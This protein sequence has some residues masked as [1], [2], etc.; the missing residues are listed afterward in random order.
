MTYTYNLVDLPDTS[1]FKIT[2]TPVTAWYVKAEKPLVA[3]FSTITPKFK[4]VKL[5]E[6]NVLRYN[7]YEAKL[8]GNYTKYNDF[9]HLGYSMAGSAKF[10]V[11]IRTPGKYRLILEGSAG[12][13]SDL[14]LTICSADV[15]FVERADGSEKM[16]TANEVVLLTDTVTV[17]TANVST[18]K[19]IVC[20][21]FEFT[22]TGYYTI[23]FKKAITPYTIGIKNI[24][25]AEIVE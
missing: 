1:D 11:E 16:N 20:A 25:L 19:D 12:G 17:N 14:E 4:A 2:V 6:T 8:L 10:A 22:E 15:T 24:R 21:D 23:R 7:V 3:E 18:F 13:S 5:S 9:I